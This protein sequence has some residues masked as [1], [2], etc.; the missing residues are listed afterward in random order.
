MFTNPYTSFHAVLTHPP[1]GNQCDCSS[2]DL[3][4]I[5]ICSTNQRFGYGRFMEPADPASVTAHILFSEHMPSF[6]QNAPVADLMAKVTL[7]L[8]ELNNMLRLSPV[9]A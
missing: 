3:V 1:G 5:T 7:K 8:I 4:F 2:L 9:I 6:S